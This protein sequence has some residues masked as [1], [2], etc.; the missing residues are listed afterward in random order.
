MCQ[1]FVVVFTEIICMLI[2]IT[3]TDPL[4]T[5]MNFVALTVITD[6]DKFSFDSI[7]AEP[8][9]LLADSELKVLMIYRTTSGYC[10][11]T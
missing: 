2:V 8:L 4:S 7:Q 9:K 1:G 6:F 3:S 5:V 11:K 10:S